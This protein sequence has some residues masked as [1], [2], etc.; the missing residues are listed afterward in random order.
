MEVKSAGEATPGASLREAGEPEDAATSSG[1]E[2]RGA[3]VAALGGVDEAAGPGD[4]MEVDGTP[5]EPTL[6]ERGESTSGSEAAANG[7]GRHVDT[8]IAPKDAAVAAMREAASAVGARVEKAVHQLVAGAEI[9]EAERSLGTVCRILENVV[10]HPTEDKYRRLR[11]ANNTVR[12]RVRG[13]TGAV[14]LLRT[15]GFTAEV[16]GRSRDWQLSM[17]L[18]DV[19]ERRK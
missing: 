1:A 2:G 4:V 10:Q 7:P 18:D 12:S 11:W 6:A 3:K 15:A 8:D 19:V 13:H 17:G 5:L 16:E 14:E 9:A